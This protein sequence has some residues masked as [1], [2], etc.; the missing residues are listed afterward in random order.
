MSSAAHWKGAV[1]AAVLPATSSGVCRQ[2]S[3]PLPDYYYLNSRLQIAPKISS[4]P[5]VGNE[6]FCYDRERQSGFYC[7]WNAQFVCFTSPGALVINADPN[8]STMN[9]RFDE[10]P[11]EEPTPLC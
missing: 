5:E 9:A 7:L 4:L 3:C 11:A 2:R 1:A 8:I 6:A 10:T